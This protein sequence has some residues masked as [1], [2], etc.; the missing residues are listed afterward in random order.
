[1]RSLFAVLLLMG[2]SL[3]AHAG[4]PFGQPF[5]LNVGA[6]L[7]LGD[8]GLNAGFVGILEDSRCPEGVTCFWEG[9]AAAHLW[10]QV[11]GQA[12]QEFVLHSAS[13]LGQQAIVLGDYTVRLVLVA[14]YPV[15]DV[16]IEPDTYVVTLVVL[17][18]AVAAEAR[19]WGTIKALY[20]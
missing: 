13:S 1:M 14:P 9:D 10:L 3:P 2:L 19:A 17:E 8:D 11:A 7:E 16:P 6:S 18:G 15:P 12:R 5:D 20:R 4:H